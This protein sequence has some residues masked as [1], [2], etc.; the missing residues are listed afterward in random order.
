MLV[1]AKS[2]SSKN[3]MSPGVTNNQL[4]TRAPVCK[5]KFKNI[6]V[7]NISSASLM[8]K[9]KPSICSVCTARG[10]KQPHNH[11]KSNKCPFHL[12]YCSICLNLKKVTN[13]HSEA[14]CPNIIANEIAKTVSINSKKTT[15]NY[16]HSLAEQFIVIKIKPDGH[17]GFNSIM[18]I[19]TLKNVKFKN[20]LSFRICISKLFDQFKEQLLK[21][22]AF[23]SVMKKKVFEDKLKARIYRQGMSEYG[24]GKDHWM[25]DYTTIPVIAGMFPGQNS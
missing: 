9:Q 10:I 23:K 3:I 12:Q 4:C 22:M 21:D 6:D 24:C 15:S 1:S 19:L 8:V 20:V 2:D 25:Q 13:L 14:N 7:T 17:C 5:K 16:Y 11:R 18:K